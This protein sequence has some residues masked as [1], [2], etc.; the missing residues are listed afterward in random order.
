MPIKRLQQDVASF[1][2]IGKLRKGSPKVEKNGKSIVGKDL[3]YFRFDTDDADAM[4]KF[5]AAYGNEPK[6]LTVYLPFHTIEENFT[7]WQEEYT[8]GGL[9]HRCD[10]ETCVIWQKPDGKYSHEPKPCPGGCKEVGRLTVII[11]ELMRFAYVSVE[12]HSLNDIMQLSRNLN[13]AFALR[14]DLAGIPFLLIRRPVEISTPSGTDGK[15]ARRTK[16]LLFLE[17][18]PEWVQVKLLE[19]RSSALGKI[20]QSEMKQLTDGRSVNTGTGEIIEGYADDDDDVEI[21]IDNPFDSSSDSLPVDPAAETDDF[22]A[23]AD[24][25][26]RIMVE[27]LCA[28]Q[29]NIHVTVGSEKQCRFA[30]GCLEVVVGK[31][32]GIKFL[33]AVFGNEFDPSTMCVKVVDWLSKMPTQRRKMLDDGTWETVA[34]EGHDADAV[35]MLSAIWKYICR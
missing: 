7:S 13:A 34:N 10:G 12:T 19:M 23:K 4:T 11:P 1:P 2:I 26:V 35:E 20:A 16:A 15:R 3:E 33:N 22:W 31:G 14:G 28:W 21:E 5:V 17:P 9:K 32:N 6:A 29:N 8:A 30:Y 25:P 18:H 27:T 24:E